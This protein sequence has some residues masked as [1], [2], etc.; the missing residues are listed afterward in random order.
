MPII[1]K[2]EGKSF[3]LVPEGNYHAVCFDVWDIGNQRISYNG[4]ELIKHKIIVG[5]ELAET[6]ESDDEFNGQRYRIYKRY[7]HSLNNKSNLCKDLTSWR[8]KPFT[9][10]EKKGFD[11]EKLIGTNCLINIIHNER[12]GKTYANITTVSPLI[13]GTKPISPENNRSI[14]D[15]INRLLSNAVVTSVG[16]PFNDPITTVADDSD[17]PIFSPLLKF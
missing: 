15:W 12:D 9:N 8:G 7:T 1:I 17:V 5:W 3:H 11:I 4:K 16:N 14:P 2:D 13:K 6:I 10:E